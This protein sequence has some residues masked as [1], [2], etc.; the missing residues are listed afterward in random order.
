MTTSMTSFAR[1]EITQTWGALVWEIRTVNHRYLEPHFRL[2]DSMRE[3][4]PRLRDLL[5]KELSRGKVECTL[6]VMRHEGC[7]QLTINQAMLQ[8][9][10]Q[11]LNTVR[12][13]I[14]QAK[15]V[16]PLEIL[17]WPGL[18]EQA[19]S[20]I[21]QIHNDAVNAFATALIQI[22]ETR[23]REGAELKQFILQRLASIS[24]ETTVVR[25]FMPE[26]LQA[27]R[28]KITQ[29]LN[30]ARVEVDQNR[31]EQELVFL[32]QKADVEEELDRLE[33]HVKEVARILN[34]QGAVGRRLDFLMQELNREAKHPWFQS[35]RSRSHPKR[36]QSEGADRTD[37]RADL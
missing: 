2:P 31:L 33:T 26:L 7:E 17:R 23:A 9:L 14:P 15:R 28:D 21:A 12:E 11:A 20:D 18:L 10:S 16:D 4:E 19:A 36:H 22:Q 27:Q 34:G 8:Q 37:A 25:Q 5:R 13:E 29:R 24:Q 6:K 3:I 1:V 32:A 35:C 30:D